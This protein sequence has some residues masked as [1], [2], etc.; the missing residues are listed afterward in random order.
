MQ[1]IYDYI[2][3]A[4]TNAISDAKKLFPEKNYSTQY[5]SS[6][7][8]RAMDAHYIPEKKKICWTGGKTK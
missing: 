8:K 5:S 4:W 3:P 7:E 6:P 1:I 2:S